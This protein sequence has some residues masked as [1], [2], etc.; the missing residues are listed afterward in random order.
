MRQFGADSP[1]IGTPMTTHGIALLHD[2][3]TNKSTAFTQLERDAEGLTGLLPS[4]VET[5]EAQLKRCQ[6]QLDKKESDIERYIYLMQLSDDNQTLFF[7]VVASD[8]ARFIPIMYDPTI[9]AACLE[10]GEIYRKP[11]GIYMSIAQRGK[12]KDVLSNWPEKDVRVICV[13][14]GGRILGL[15][16][17]GANGMGIPIGKLQLYTACA[18]VPPGG[19]LPVLLDCGTENEKL[20]AD[21]FYLGLRQKRASTADLD[22]FFEEFVEAVQQ[23]YPKC[24]LHFEDWKGTDAERLLKKYTNRICCYNDDIQGTG[25]VV[26]AGVYNALKITGGKLE[27]QRVLF[28][29][30]GSAAVGIAN[31]LVAAMELEGLSE[32]AA[33]ERISLFDV[34]GLIEPSRAR[35]TPDQQRYVHPHA[36][37]KKILEAIASIKPTIL[38]GVSTVGG[39][40]AK[41]VVEAMT[42]LNPRPIIF[43]L[44]NPTDKAECT[45]EQAYAWSEGKAV[46]A[47]GVQFPPVKL[48]GKTY[49]PGQA[50]NF[51]IYPAMGLAIFAT[52]AKQAPDALFVEAAKALAAQVDQGGLA[53]GMLFPPQKDILAVEVKTAVAVANKVFEL[54]LARVD[55]PA[56]V[57][58]WVQ[59]LLYKP[60]YAEPA[61]ARH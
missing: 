49:R 18:G 29:G 37:T 19:L 6:W 52:E 42:K 53:K 15:G 38:I 43:A 56:D 9:A 50:N 3:A 51:Y 4:A 1:A 5:L 10:F 31:T 25:S 44:S 46:F 21:P 17:I 7:K 61:I 16:D 23:L 11:N 45:A 20:R 58:A 14:T 26:L 2:S 60:E 41:D 55:K 47:G 8:P 40:F 36:P 33:R 57:A 12:V 27:D 39:A 24:C 35:L 13:S 28:F 34:D 22:S 54:G 32:A 48:N 59:S 30:A